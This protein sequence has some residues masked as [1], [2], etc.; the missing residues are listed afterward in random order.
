MAFD[1]ANF[2]ANTRHMCCRID[3]AEQHISLVNRNRVCIH[4]RLSKEA[5]STRVVVRRA[6]RGAAPFVWEINKDAMSEPVYV[7]PEA[8]VTMEAAFVAG[9]SRL[10][11]FTPPQMP[12][13]SPVESQF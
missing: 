13:P 7:S 6:R 1:H 9:Q 11:E 12:T 10:A 4:M 2:I 5:L 3:V 8:F